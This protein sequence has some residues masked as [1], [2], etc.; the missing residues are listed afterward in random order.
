MKAMLLGTDVKAWWSLFYPSRIAQIAASFFAELQLL[1]ILS[2]FVMQE[3]RKVAKQYPS[4]KAEEMIVDN[5]CM[6]L[7]GTI[8]LPCHDSTLIHLTK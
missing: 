5:T 3:F 8:H 4:I 7:T 1:E 2:Q 6:Q